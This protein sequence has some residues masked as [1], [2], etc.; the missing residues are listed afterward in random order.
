MFLKCFEYGL[1]EFGPLEKI[2]HFNVTKIPELIR[3]V[4][5]QSYPTRDILVDTRF[6]TV[7]GYIKKKKKNPFKW[8][9][10]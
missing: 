3:C 6:V 7:F 9:Y 5:P 8:M 2:I 10:I 1:D 4:L